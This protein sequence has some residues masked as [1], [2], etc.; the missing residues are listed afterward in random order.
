MV[1][2]CSR[3]DNRASHRRSTTGCSGDSSVLKAIA[4]PRSPAS[5]HG[6]ALNAD[7]TKLYIGTENADVPGVVVY[8]V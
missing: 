3:R 7:N 1:W 8:D 5:P 6:M 2:D 4:S